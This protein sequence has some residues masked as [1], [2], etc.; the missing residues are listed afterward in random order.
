MTNWV[1]T[2]CTVEGD[3]A[4]IA[5]FKD[6]MIHRRAD[7]STLFNL[8]AAVPPPEWMTI[9]YT[10]PLAAAIEVLTGRTLDHFDPFWN[11]CLLE[12]SRGVV[13]IPDTPIDLAKS[14]LTWPWVRER[15][16]ATL[17][18]MRARLETKNPEALVAAD[19][20]I[21]SHQTTGFITWWD[22]AVENWCT[23][24]NA[25]DF[26]NEKTDDQ[27]YEFVFDTAHSFPFPIFRKLGSEFPA[28]V[29]TCECLVEFG[30][31][32]GYCR[33]AGQSFELRYKEYSPE[34]HPLKG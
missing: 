9:Q 11:D 7:G 6:R 1:I 26:R 2:H 4:E 34:E 8:R 31:W 21:A 3:N 10:E 23:D 22:W 12:A 19:Q 33:A 14:C 32:G 5:R 17:A 16:I 18:D 29:L 30:D 20:Y 28:L 15:G 25:V 13:G 27:R 24:R